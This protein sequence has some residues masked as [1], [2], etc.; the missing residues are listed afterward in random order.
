[1]KNKTLLLLSVVLGL[2]GGFLWAGSFPGA[3]SRESMVTADNLS[4]LSVGV[5][6][7]AIQ[8]D[9][10][11]GGAGIANTLEAR[12][13]DGFF[14]VDMTPWLSPFFTLGASSVLDAGSDEYGDYKL[15]WSVG[16]NFNIWHY[17]IESPDF[18]S[19]RLSIESMVEY[20]RYASENVGNEGNHVKWTDLTAILP[21]C[22]EM[23]E[24]ISPIADKSLRTSLNLYAGPALSIVDGTFSARDASFAEDQRFGFIGGVDIFLAEKVSIGAHMLVFD[25]ASVTATLRYHF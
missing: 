4:R 13:I 24:D 9:I 18:L 20:A 1:M 6:Y 10:L 12:S 22:Y 8:R 3:I 19:G 5:D 2:Q 14:A 23:F 15:K 17:D 16:L 21:I 7:E 25:Q 11:V